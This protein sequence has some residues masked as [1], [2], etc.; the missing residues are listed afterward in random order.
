MS[1]YQRGDRVKLLVA[2]CFV[3]ECFAR[4]GVFHARVLTSDRWQPGRVVVRLDS[5]PCAHQASVL[6][7]S[8]E[9]LTIVSAI[10]LLGELA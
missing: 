10:D 3:P 9:A 2:G 1:D 4:C 5:K 7:V 6:E 8:A